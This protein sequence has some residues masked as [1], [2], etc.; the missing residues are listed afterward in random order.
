MGVAH[1]SKNLLIVM[2]LYGHVMGV[3]HNSS[4]IKK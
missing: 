1:K 2:T 4:F 3:A